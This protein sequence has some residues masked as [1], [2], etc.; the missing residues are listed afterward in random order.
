MIGTGF[1]A[2]EAVEALRA[3]VRR[4]TEILETALAE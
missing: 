3:T 4:R 2:L 1:A